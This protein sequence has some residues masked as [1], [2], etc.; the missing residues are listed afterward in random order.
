MKC[1]AKM[2]RRREQQQ[3]E[4]TWTVLFELNK[5][6]WRTSQSK[7]TVDS[8]ISGTPARP[9]VCECPPP[10]ALAAGRHFDE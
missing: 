1:I 2:N 7:N 3:E 9:R 5:I 10:L 8:L 4:K 6:T